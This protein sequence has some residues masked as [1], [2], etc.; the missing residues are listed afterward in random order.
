[1]RNSSR[2]ETYLLE[3]IKCTKFLCPSE[4]SQKVQEL[5]GEKSGLQVFLVESL[6]EMLLGDAKH[7]PH[8]CSY[9][10]V[11]WDPVRVLLSSGHTGKTYPS[12]ENRREELMQRY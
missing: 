11:R 5:Q 9:R 6:D 7:Y 2:A 12:D 3:Q 4:M 8:E 1:M 10:Y